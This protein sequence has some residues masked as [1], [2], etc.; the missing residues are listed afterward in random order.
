MKAS[1][2]GALANVLGSTGPPPRRFPLF[3][4]EIPPYHNLHAEAFIGGKISVSRANQTSSANRQAVAGLNGKVP[5]SRSR[6]RL[7]S[8][9][10]CVF[11]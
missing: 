9:P 2:L 7:T 11:A 4:Y 6:S 1:T 5:V 8:S 10:S 3:L